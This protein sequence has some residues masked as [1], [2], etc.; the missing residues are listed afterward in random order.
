MPE[1]TFKDLSLKEYN[2]TKRVQ[3]LKDA[4]F[5]AMP[6]ICVNSIKGTLL[7]KLVN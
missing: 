1:I 3:G 6:E 5:K 4:Y 7:F 2:L